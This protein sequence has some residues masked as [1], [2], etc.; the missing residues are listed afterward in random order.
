MRVGMVRVREILGWRWGGAVERVERV[1]D[2]VRGAVDRVE[3]LWTEWVMLS[4]E[5]SYTERD[6]QLICKNSICFDNI[7]SYF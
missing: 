6:E 7:F 5:C 1:M 3:R 2:R 4:T